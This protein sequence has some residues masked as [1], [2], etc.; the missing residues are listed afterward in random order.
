MISGAAGE[1]DASSGLGTGKAPPRRRSRRDTVGLGLKGSALRLMLALL[2]L[3]IC[4]AVLGSVCAA[5]AVAPADLTAPTPVPPGDT[6]PDV[7]YSKHLAARLDCAACHVDRPPATQADA[8]TC[9]TCHGPLAALVEKTAAD[10]PNPHAKSHIGLLSC[11]A[12]HHI[13]VLSESFCNKCHSF[14]MN[15]P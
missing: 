4:G 11:T 3:V 7:L 13:H 6:V 1:S 12:C 8:S 5:N 10:E 2:L 14:D 9:L 15:V